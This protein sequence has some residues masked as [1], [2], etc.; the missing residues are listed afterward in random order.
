MTCGGRFQGPAGIATAAPT[1][2][3]SLSVTRRYYAPE[4]PDSGGYVQLSD[5]EARH[6]ARVMR[7]QVGDPITLFDGQG[8]ECE[9]TIESI[10]KRNCLVQAGVP[11]VV[12]REP[13]C[14]S[15]FGVAFPKPERA[16]EMVERL[17]EL[18]VHRLTPLVCDRTQRPPTDSLLAKLRRI[19]VESSKQC[20][21]NVLMEI[22]EP[23]PL[24]EFLQ[25]ASGDLRLIAHPEGSQLHAAIP[26]SAEPSTACVLIGPEGGF[27]DPEVTE[28]VRSGYVTVGLGTRIYRV[29]TA[30]S[31]IA[32]W[33]A[34]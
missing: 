14:R 6:A 2:T 9:A 27:T 33:L 7:A 20:E 24:G 32:A 25:Q 1:S 23:V 8:R 30:A 31:V 16:K 28:A 18:G 22:T 13:R 4:L 11:A 3:R 12:D 34:S 5:D 10:D 29:E 19:V 17:T 26:H 21:R 15:H